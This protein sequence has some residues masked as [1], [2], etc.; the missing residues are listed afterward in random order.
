MRLKNRLALVIVLFLS[1]FVGCYSLLLL[2]EVPERANVE[3]DGALPWV[4]RLLPG[5][6]DTSLRGAA[7]QR[8]AL[9]TLVHGF[10]GIRHVRVV[11][12][13]PDG[14]L[15]ARASSP[16]KP[17][18]SWLGARAF[19]RGRGGGGRGWSRGWRGRKPRHARTSWT[20]SMC[21]P[22]SR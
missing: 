19:Q 2:L 18:P 10:D 5:H 6:V 13:G 16:G 14:G 1:T 15:L 9:A 11:L 21:S 22:T 3:T 8:Q 17:G 4:I 20:A 12:R 7:A